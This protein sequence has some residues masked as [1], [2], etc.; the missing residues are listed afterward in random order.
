MAD[1]HAPGAEFVVYDQEVVVEYIVFQFS[2]S[3]TMSSSIFIYLII[4]NV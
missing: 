4:P 3:S 1:K 2:L